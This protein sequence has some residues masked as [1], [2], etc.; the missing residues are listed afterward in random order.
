VLEDYVLALVRDRLM[1]PDAVRAFVAAYHQEIN[2]GCDAAAAERARRQKEL[3]ARRL[4]LEGL[5]DAVAGGLRTGGIVLRIQAL[6]EEVVALEAALAPPSP[7]VRPVAANVDDL[8]L[9]KVHDL[10]TS[11]ADPLIREEAIMHLRALTDRVEVAGSRDGQSVTVFGALS[12]MGRATCTKGGP[13][14]A[15][16]RRND[17]RSNEAPHDHHREEAVAPSRGGLPVEWRPRIRPVRRYTVVLAARPLEGS[18]RVVRPWIA[19]FTGSLSS[20]AGTGRDARA[21]L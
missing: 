18:F 19:T 15:R 13:R 17:A 2:A 4:K 9:S 12:G 11:L 14:S 16:T 7:E 10:A 3:A 20:S 1:E 21:R 8:Y 5:Y 6:E